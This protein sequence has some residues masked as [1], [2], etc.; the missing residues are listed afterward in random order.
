MLTTPLEI[1]IE[2]L[3]ARGDDHGNFVELHERISQLWSAYLQMVIEP[4]QVAALMALLKIARSEF[5]ASNEDNFV[6]LAGYGAIYAELLKIAARR[7]P[8]A[9]KT[10]PRDTESPESEE[11]R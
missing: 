5:N 11:H 3:A 2:V 10:H 6:D 4:H 7:G 1:A 8:S 9:R